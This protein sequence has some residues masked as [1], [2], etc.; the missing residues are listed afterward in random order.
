MKNIINLTSM[1]LL[2]FTTSLTYAQSVVLVNGIPTSVSLNGTDIIAVHGEVENYMDGYK[3]APNNGGFIYANPNTSD[4]SVASTTATSEAK[5]L[6]INKTKISSAPMVSG[7]YFKFGQK[8]AILTEVAIKEIQDHS[9]KWKEGN[10]KS[11]LLESY[12][13][14][15]SKSSI[16]LVRNRLDACKK[17]FEINGVPPNAI[18]I[19]IYPNE[20]ESDKVSVTLR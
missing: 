18:V 9:R 2:M 4:T 13:K 14:I 17:Y 5:S 20:V 3:P 11:I 16:K 1:I 6:V 19:N 12:H 15:N 7:N 10:S 8:S